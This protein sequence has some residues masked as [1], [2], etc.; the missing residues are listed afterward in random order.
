MRQEKKVMTSSTLYCKTE[1]YPPSFQTSSA[2]LQLLKSSVDIQTKHRFWSYSQASILQP[3][4]KNTVSVSFP[5]GTVKKP[6]RISNVQYRSQGWTNHFIVFLFLW[7]T[8]FLREE[9]GI[10]KMERDAHITYLASEADKSVSACPGTHPQIRQHNQHVSNWYTWVENHTRNGR[11]WTELASRKGKH[12]RMT[13]EKQ[14]IKP[15]CWNRAMRDW[16]MWLLFSALPLLLGTSVISANR[17]PFPCISTSLSLQQSD[18]LQR[19]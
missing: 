15:W 16:W 10:H 5:W 11:A 14:W 18:D 9:G 2:I 3:Q 8:Q 4:D 19:A 12:N 6:V 7:S 13:K 17:L 1:S